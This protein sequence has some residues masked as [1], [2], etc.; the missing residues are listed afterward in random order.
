MSDY[1]LTSKGKFVLGLF[2]LVLVFLIVYSG[3]YIVRYISDDI[4]KSPVVLETNEPLTDEETSIAES[5]ET[6]NIIT[7]ETVEETT[8]PKVETSVESTESTEA[9]GSIEDTIYSMTDL[10]DLS[11]FKITFYFTKDSDEIELST[12]DLSSIK[13]MIN[14][15]PN[16]KIAV[17]GYVNGYPSYETNEAADALS[18]SRAIRIENALEKIGVEKSLINVYNFGSES[19]LFTDFGKQY[20]N[21]RVEVYFLDHFIKASQGK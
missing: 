8:G 5:V 15:Y 1:R 7:T 18:L 10:E 14:Q 3:S 21:D 6:S 20:K 9:S 11:Q 4:K 19:P 16:E 13:A 2:I 17:E 12:E